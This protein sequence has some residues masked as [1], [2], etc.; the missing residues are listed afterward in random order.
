VA[1]ASAAVA[2][3]IAVHRRWRP[4]EGRDLLQPQHVAEVARALAVTRQPALPSRVAVAHTSLGLR[5]SGGQIADDSTCTA[6]Y[7]LS[8]SGAALSERAAE[9]LA[10]LILQLTHATGSAQL[11]HGQASVFHLL[12]RTPAP[13]RKGAEP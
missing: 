6:N 12:V 7:T 2:L 8:R 10:R 1:A 4:A 11:I 5:I 9:R 3:G 13:A